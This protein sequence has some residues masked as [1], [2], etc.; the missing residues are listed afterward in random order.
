[1]IA[2]EKVFS[3]T[4]FI[5]IEQKILD[6]KIEKNKLVKRK[7]EL[8]SSLIHCQNQYK[9]VTFRSPEFQEI[10]ERRNILKNQLTGVELEIKRINADITEKNRTRLEVDYFINQNKSSSDVDSEKLITKLNTLKAKYKDFTK[11]R[12]RIASLRIMASEFIDELE[13]LT[14]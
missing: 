7:M 6:L 8:E 10:K 12:T 11:D 14:K 2:T 13:K 5:I 3:K 9:A 4:D 1:M